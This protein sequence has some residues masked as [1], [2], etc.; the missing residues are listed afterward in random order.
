MRVA[1]LGRGLLIVVLACGCGSHRPYE[2]TYLRASDNW[3][4]RAAY[5]RADRLFNAFDYGHSILSETLLRHPADAGQRLDGPVYLN[6]LCEVL[7]HPPSVPLAEQAVGPTWGREF[8]EA[9]AT[10]EWAHLLHRQI[11]DIIADTRLSTEAQRRRIDAALAYYRSRPDLAL[12]SIPKSMELMEGQPYSLAFRRAAPRYNALI[13]SYHWLQMALYDA[14]LDNH[15]SDARRMAVDTTVDRF[16]QMADDEAGPRF[17]SMPMSAATAPR[18]TAE[19]PD[20]AIIFDNLHALHDVVS[21]ILTSA[22][23]RPEQRHAAIV[24]ALARYRDDTSSTT[25]RAE[26]L[27]MGVSMGGLPA[28]AKIISPSRSRC[29]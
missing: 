14:M 6:V 22:T 11:Y 29:R 8:P 10:F 26:W 21:D 4:F 16:Y 13:W 27:E 1:A 20:A 5:P 15:A 19:Y 23:V 2:Q 9:V 25:S 12:S 17:T 7:H 24:S 28:Q 18:F 3:H